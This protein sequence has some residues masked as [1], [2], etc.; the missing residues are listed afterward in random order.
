M[1]T[2]V[3]RT[4]PTTAAP[5]PARPSSPARGLSH[6][7]LRRLARGQGQPAKRVG[8]SAQ[9]SG[10]GDPHPLCMSVA[11]DIAQRP[12]DRRPAP[13][14]GRSS[15]TDPRPPRGGAVDGPARAWCAAWH[16]GQRSS[17]AGGSTGI[18]RMITA[19]RVSRC[20]TITA[21]SRHMPA[22]QP[23]QIPTAAVRR[24]DSSRQSRQSIGRLRSLGRRDP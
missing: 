4:N 2:I 6:P 9:S 19:V 21:W 11:L 24:P 5:P 16:V 10:G 15:A 1:G 3:V 13:K 22:P 8:Q 7:R 18:S 14:T 12:E 20:S 23:V 17:R